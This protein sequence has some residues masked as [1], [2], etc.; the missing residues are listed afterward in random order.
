MKKCILCHSDELISYGDEIH[1][2]IFCKNCFDKYSCNHCNK[3]NINLQI[4]DSVVVNFEIKKLY[5]QRVGKG[6]VIEPLVGYG[7]V[8]KL[9]CKEC[10]DT[11]DMYKD[12]DDMSVEPDEDDLESYCSEDFDEDENEI[13]Y[14][15][16]DSYYAG[17][18]KYEIY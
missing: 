7:F 14:G 5:G 17:K 16:L 4:K 18:G 11:Q 9:Y 2:E 6:S 3:M 8:F 12:E 1:G 13:G 10:W 15:N